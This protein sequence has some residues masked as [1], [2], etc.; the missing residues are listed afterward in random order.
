ITEADDGYYKIENRKSRKILGPDEGSGDNGTKI[1]Q[2]HDGGWGTQHWDLVNAGAGFYK[3]KNKE[4]G[5]VIDLAGGSW[6]NG[7]DIVLW[8]EK[9]GNQSLYNKINQ[10]WQLVKVGYSD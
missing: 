9:N 4:N 3:I 7:A 8:N 1:V 5:K 6:D 2:W 10:H